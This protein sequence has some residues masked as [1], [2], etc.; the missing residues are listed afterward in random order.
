MSASP[1]PAADRYRRAPSGLVLSPDGDAADPGRKTDA[2]QAVVHVHPAGTDVVERAVTVPDAVRDSP[3]DAEGDGEGEPGEHRGPPQRRQLLAEGTPNVPRP[4]AS[5]TAGNVPAAPWARGAEPRAI[6]PR[7]VV[8]RDAGD[9]MAQT[10]PG[11]RSVGLGPQ[12]WL[13]WLTVATGRADTGIEKNPRPYRPWSS[14]GVRGGVRG[15][16]RYI[17]TRLW[18]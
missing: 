12:G 11:A 10:E 1:V 13:T 7:R 4:R 17:R 16:T 8:V 14:F 18:L 6:S 3:D 9:S 5:C 15:A 2:P